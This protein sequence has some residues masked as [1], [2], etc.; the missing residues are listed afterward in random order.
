MARPVKVRRVCEEPKY[1]RFMPVGSDKYDAVVLSIEEFEVMRHV[2]YQKMTHEECARHMAISRTTAT[3]LYES[4][5]AKIA[6]EADA[7]VAVIQ[8]TADKEVLQI[9]ADAAEYAGKKDAAVND[10]ISRSLTDILIE[11]YKIKQWNG[12]LPEYFV[13]GTDT[14]L[15]ILGQAAAGSGSEAAPAAP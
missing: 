11:Y 15:P 3:E 12:E 2:D 10:A 14:V 8:A 9:Q 4:A 5:R 13:S 7:S 1:T 6:A